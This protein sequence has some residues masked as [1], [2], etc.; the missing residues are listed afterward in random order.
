MKRHP[1][2]RASKSSRAVI[3]EFHSWVTGHA[4]GALGRTEEE[5]AQQ[6]K[7]WAEVYSPETVWRLTDELEPRLLS[8]ARTLR[9]TWPSSLQAA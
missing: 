5:L 6:I 4:I 7:K 1:G 3:K 2:R 8:A 9:L